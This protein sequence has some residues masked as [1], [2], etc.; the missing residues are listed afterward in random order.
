MNT[1]TRFLSVAVASALAVSLAASFSPRATAQD[2]APAAPAPPPAPVEVAQAKAT[3]LAP[4]LWAPASVVS[5]E[6][7][8]VASEQDGRV[9]RVAEVGVSVQRGD[10]LAQLDDALLR[11]QERQNLSELERI[12]ARL[13]YART[14][15]QRLGQLVQKHSIAGGAARR[16]AL[17][18]AGAGTG[19]AGRARGAGP[20]P[21]SAA[22]RHGARALSTVPWWSASSRAGNTSAP[23]WPWCA[24]STRSRWK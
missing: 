24:W 21:A 22:Q 15:E 23:A 13:D 9:V 16:G 20:D 7:A 14:Q 2:A 12:Q 6:D 17:A 4:L 10:T 8:R 3:Q 18:A 19:A 5:R 1:A 11:L